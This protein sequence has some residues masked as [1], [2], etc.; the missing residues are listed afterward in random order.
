MSN[1]P[2]ERYKAWK[3][4]KNEKRQQQRN[5][6]SKPSAVTI[7]SD[8]RI[9]VNA[10]NPVVIMSADIELNTSSRLQISGVINGAF[11]YVCGIAIYI[12]GEPIRR[13]AGTNQCHADCFQIMYGN[14]N[15]GWMSATPYDIATEQLQ[16]GNH[17]VAVGVIGKWAEIKRPVY[18]NNRNDNDM[19]SS[20]SLIV[21][22][23]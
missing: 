2:S 12:D 11:Y 4:I 18:I 1:M 16:P 21:R 9:T 7:N 15:H 3:K 8:A 10:D 5:A 20:S 14:G 19:A 17:V 13:G 22:A 6:H 23:L